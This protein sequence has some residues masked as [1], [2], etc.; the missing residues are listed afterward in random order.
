MLAAGELSVMVV[1]LEKFTPPILTLAADE[2]KLV[3]L[4][5]RYPLF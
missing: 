4:A 3:V 1:V 2:G 5:L